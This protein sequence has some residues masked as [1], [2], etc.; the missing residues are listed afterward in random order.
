MSSYQ[1]QD[2]KPVT[3]W[4][5][6]NP[7]FIIDFQ[8]KL[9]KRDSDEAFDN[10]FQEFKYTIKLMNKMNN[11]IKTGLIKIPD[12]L[13]PDKE[14]MDKILKIWF[15]NCY[16]G[17]I[18]DEDGDTVFRKFFYEKPPAQF[19][20]NGE[21]YDMIPVELPPYARL[22]PVNPI[23]EDTFTIQVRVEAMLSTFFSGAS[24][25]EV[26]VEG[27]FVNEENGKLLPKITQEEFAEGTMM[28]HYVHRPVYFMITGDFAERIQPLID[29]LDA[30]WQKIIEY[31]TSGKGI[32]YEDDMSDEEILSTIIND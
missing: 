25:S 31:V 18:Q 32:K 20:I 28:V 3:K 10:E 13:H 15:G 1:K 12:E 17:I 9:G 6:R 8:E 23:K 24:Y 2:F 4:T 16:Y 26:I 30:D 29:L 11:A 22:V 7:Q 21:M 19:E 27:R 5:P 14:V